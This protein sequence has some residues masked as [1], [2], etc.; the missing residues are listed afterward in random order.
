MKFTIEYD[1]QRKTV[2]AKPTASVLDVL[3]IAFPAIAKFD[4]EKVVIVSSA[5]G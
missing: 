4:M 5:K 2:S 1:G 3:E